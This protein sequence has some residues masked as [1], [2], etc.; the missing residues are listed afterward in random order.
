[1]GNNIMTAFTVAAVHTL[2][3][4]FAGGAIAVVIYVWLGLKFLSRTWF[5]LDVIWALSLILV[6]AFGVYSA[7]AGHTS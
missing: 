1:M 5:N 7:T 2:S 4:T 3:M 6:G